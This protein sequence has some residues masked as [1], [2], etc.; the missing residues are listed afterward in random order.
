MNELLGYL[1]I[2]ENQIHSILNRPFIS[3]N[4]LEVK[5]RLALEEEKNA[6]HGAISALENSGE[7]GPLLHYFLSIL[8][9]ADEVGH[10]SFRA[11]ARAAS[12]MNLA[13]EDTVK[14]LKEVFANMHQELKDAAPVIQKLFNQQNAKYIVPPMYR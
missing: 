14:R 3:S 9:R 2:I 11:W 1:R 13:D 7:G 5:F 4:P 6:V 12:W 10:A 8:Y